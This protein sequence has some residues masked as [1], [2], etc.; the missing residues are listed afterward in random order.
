MKLTLKERFLAKVSPDPNSGCWLW[1]GCY[2]AGGYGRFKLSPSKRCGAHRASWILFRG[3][4]PQGLLVCHKCDIRACVNPEHLFLAT[5]EQNMADM[6]RKGRAR[7]GERFHAAKLTA[8]QVRQI[9][10]LLAQGQLT[11]LQIARQFGVGC[12]AI[13]AISCGR[14]WRRVTAVFPSSEPNT[15]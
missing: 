11:H 6:R 15:T 7:S 3:E 8:A 12:G 2:F 13:A 4:I 9:K 14:T 5:H 10:Q 1:K